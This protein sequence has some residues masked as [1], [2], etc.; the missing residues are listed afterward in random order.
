MRPARAAPAAASP[1]S[2]RVARRANRSSLA[3]T[4]RIPRST[5]A[6]T[7]LVDRA[8][9]L[10]PRMRPSCSGAPAGPYHGPAVGRAGAAHS[11]RRRRCKAAEDLRRALI[12]RMSFFGFG[13]E[14]AGAL[15]VC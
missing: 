1:G 6:S 12:A 7:A 4:G 9:E 3:L 14:A 10:P 11:I 15:V 2:R 13:A 5:P 8:N